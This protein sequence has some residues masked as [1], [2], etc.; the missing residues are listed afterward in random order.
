[1]IILSNKHI[2]GRTLTP[3]GLHILNHH[4]YFQYEPSDIWGTQWLGQGPSCRWYRWYG[5][6]ASWIR[7]MLMR[8]GFVFK[9]FDE[10][11][12]VCVCILSS[13]IGWSWKKTIRYWVATK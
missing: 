9:M 8:T 4:G 3:I 10:V 2:M 6:G 12:T 13:T 5:H 11:F 1:M 7:D